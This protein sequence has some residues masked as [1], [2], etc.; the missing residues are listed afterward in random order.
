MGTSSLYILKM[1]DFVCVGV[2]ISVFR[3]ICYQWFHQNICLYILKIHYFEC[4]TQLESI[5]INKPEYLG[6]NLKVPIILKYDSLFSTY[7]HT[8]MFTHISIYSYTYINM[9]YTHIYTDK[10]GI[11]TL[12][13]NI[14]HILKL[15]ILK[16]IYFEI[17]IILKLWKENMILFS[18]A[19]T[20]GKNAHYSAKYLS[21]AC[22]Y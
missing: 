11:Y 21:D 14:Y 10:I 6:L 7:T 20:I 4:W 15:W 13:I 2:C 17:Y 9:Q 22:Y 5:L 19:V 12:Y 18:V 16:Y 1:F 8:Y 3:N